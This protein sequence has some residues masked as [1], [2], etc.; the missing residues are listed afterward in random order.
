MRIRLHDEADR[1][2]A[3]AA[4]LLL[5]TRSPVLDLTDRAATAPDLSGAKAAALATAG[6]AGLPVLPGKVITTAAPRTE[7]LGG[8]SP[9]GTFGAL[10][11]AAWSELSQ[12]GRLPLAVR[13]SSTAEDGVTSSMAGVFTSILDVKGWAAFVD[14]VATVLASADGAPMAVLVQPML[15]ASRGG[16]LFGVDPVTGRTDRLVA[17]VV[18]GG[19]ATL[20]GGTVSG[21][22]HV[23]GR[24]GRLHEVDGGP[25]SVLLDRRTRRSLA[26]LAAAAARVFAGPQDIEWAIDGRGQL[27][28]LQSRPVT[29]VG[30][31][32]G[33]TGPRLGPG[34]VAETFPEPLTPLEADLWVAPLRAGLR[35]ALALTGTAPFRR[36]VASPVVTIVG[37]RVAVDLDLIDPSARRG[38]LRRLDPRPPARRL[39]AAW[40]VGRLRQA[41]PLLAADAIQQTDRDL[42]A[43]PSLAEMGD[44]ELLTLLGRCRLALRA[45]HGQEVLAGMIGSALPRRAGPGTGPEGP[46]GSAIALRALA[47]ARARGLDAAATVAHHPVVL[48]LVPPAIGRSPEL[49]PTPSGIPVDGSLSPE[50]LGDREALRLRARW[51]QELSGRAAAELGCRLHRRQQLPAPSLVRWLRL[52]ELHAAVSGRPLPSDLAARSM[53]PVAPPLPAVFRLTPDGTVVAERPRAGAPPQGR[54]AGGPR[55]MGPVHDPASGPPQ[56]GEV[57]VVDVLDP[58]L[59]AVLPGLAGLVAETGSVLS[60]LAI[61]AREMGVPTVVGVTE[62]R[63]RFPPGITVMVDGTSGEVAAMPGQVT[64]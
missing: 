53:A 34:P 59:A 29:A 15:G 33:A 23:L 13:S 46:T 31:T 8:R 32:V 10:L 50:E 48:A 6:A 21:T 47:D 7:L 54:G 43:V 57:L 51:L 52:D 5:S 38:L 36:L 42:T 35:E 17:E 25:G 49:P 3:A 26:G 62:A 55:Q 1:C 44:D 16:V 63:R 12:A 39:A 24:R 2:G 4:P 58:S 28:L 20:V 19:P 30:S 60:H 18:A 11:S 14:A 27:W 40:R 45:V 41:L 61:L 37:G 22:R 56:P 9:T 64:P